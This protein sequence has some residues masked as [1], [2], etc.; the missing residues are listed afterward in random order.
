MQAQMI[1]VMFTN[2]CFRRTNIWKKQTATVL[3]VPATASAAPTAVVEYSS[4]HTLHINIIII[5][6]WF[7]VDTSQIIS[8]FLLDGLGVSVS[9]RLLF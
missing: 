6:R 7:T 1:H 3:C 8:K 4:R 9:F 2:D 5:F